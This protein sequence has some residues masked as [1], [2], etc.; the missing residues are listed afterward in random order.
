MMKNL[1]EILLLITAVLCVGLMLGIFIGRFIPGRGVVL[2]T[3]DK[4]TADESPQTLPYRGENAG[5][6]NINLAN[7]KQ[8]SLLPGIGQAYAQRI[9]DYRTVHGPFITIEEITKVDGISNVRYEAIKE[10]ITVGG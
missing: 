5:K 10:Y 9:V 4:N 6:I 3:Y 7:V 8:L 2:S 1:D